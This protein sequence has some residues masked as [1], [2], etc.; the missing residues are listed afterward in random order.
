[1][2]DSSL[3]PVYPTASPAKQSKIGIASLVLGILSLI[4]LCIGMI[5]SIS[6]GVSLGV[7]NPYTTDPYA[8]VDQA[9]PAI[10]AA[11][12][13][14]YCT[15]VIS[16]IGV[17]LG[18]AAVVQKK[19]KKTLGIIGLVINSLLL[20]GVCLLLGLGLMMTAGSMG[21]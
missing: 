6:Y 3:P 8:L 20:L 1:M 16:L 18:I 5:I 19:D 13:F 12:L 14:I 9:S 7:D 21:I 11:S 15:P 4:F 2:Y 10:L 17:G